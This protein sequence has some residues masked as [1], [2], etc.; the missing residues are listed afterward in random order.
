MAFEIFN[1][2]QQAVLIDRL[3]QGTTQS[4]LR[5]RV[6]RSDAEGTEAP[7]LATTFDTNV[8]RFAYRVSSR[9][10]D[11]L[12]PFELRVYD[13][14]AISTIASR[15]ESPSTTAPPGRKSRQIQVIS[16]EEFASHNDSLLSLYETVKTLVTGVEQLAVDALAE[17]DSKLVGETKNSQDG[18]DT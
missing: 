4:A 3:I 16:T 18:S 15:T 17:L 8:G 14:G 11:D 2:K 9:D 5:W 13:F 10:G 1:E 7:E 6:S 12:A